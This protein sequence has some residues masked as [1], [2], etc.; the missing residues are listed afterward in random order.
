LTNRSWDHDLDPADL[1][2]ADFAEPGR[3]GLSDD[4]DLDG[5]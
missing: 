5:A 3:G 2:D 1:V 4:G